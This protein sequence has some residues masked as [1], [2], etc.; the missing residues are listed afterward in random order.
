ME[1]EEIYKRLDLTLLNSPGNCTLRMVTKQDMIDHDIEIG[2]LSVIAFEVL[3]GNDVMEIMTVNLQSIEANEI[4]LSHYDRATIGFIYRQIKKAIDLKE[5]VRKAGH[6][7]IPFCKFDHGDYLRYLAHF[8]FILSLL[9]KSAWTPE[10]YYKDTLE[11]I[12]RNAGNWGFDQISDAI[13]EISNDLGR[14]KEDL[15]T[16]TEELSQCILMMET[17]GFEL[18]ELKDILG[19]EVERL[20]TR[21]A[22]VEE[23]EMRFESEVEEA[24]EEVKRKKQEL[25]DAMSDLIY[26]IQDMDTE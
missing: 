25:D 23:W 20:S 9:P 16:A 24:K 1:L 22:F 18:G 11:D 8:K 26:T 3:D 19:Q 4:C 12:Q 21:G 2:P 13:E 5:A 10:D 7:C 15:H 6:P 14:A 17:E